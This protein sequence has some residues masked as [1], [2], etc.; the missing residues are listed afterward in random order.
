MKSVYWTTKQGNKIR[1]DLLK[2]DHIINI[3]KHFN[4]NFVESIELEKTLDYVIKEAR[5][6][7]IKQH[8]KYIDYETSMECI[9]LSSFNEYWKE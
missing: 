8:C 2:D 9:S 1:I 3:L 6:R 4:G 7:K 5:R